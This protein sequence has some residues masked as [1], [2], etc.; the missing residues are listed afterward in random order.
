MEKAQKHLLV[1]G[2]GRMGVAKCL[3]FKAMA[4]HAMMQIMQHERG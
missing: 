1:T 4:Y 3:N 2:E